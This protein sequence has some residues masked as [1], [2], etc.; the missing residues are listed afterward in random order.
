MLRESVK[1]EKKWLNIKKKMGKKGKK[2][3]K[4]KNKKNQI[5]KNQTKKQRKINGKWAIK[6]NSKKI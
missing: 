6:K 4:V 2:A 3:K 1:I 5:L